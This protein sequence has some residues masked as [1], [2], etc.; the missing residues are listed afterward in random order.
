MEIHG[1][2][3]DMNPTTNSEWVEATVA[4]IITETPTVKRFVF[5][6]PRIVSHLAG[7][8][9]E[10]RLTGENGYQAARLYSAAS[11][12]QGNNSLELTI[13]YMQDGEV[14]PYMH[15]GVNIGD[16]LELRGPLGKFF[17]WN[18]TIQDP[19]LLIGAGSGV[20]PMKTILDAHEK[21]GVNTPINLLYSTRSF[22]DIIYKDT[23]LGN[24]HTTITLSRTS[25]EG[26]GGK[27]GRIDGELVRAS[28]R[29][30][31][32]PPLC[33]ICGVTSFVEAVAT[34]LQ[35]N[36]IPSQRIKAERYGA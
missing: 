21:A 6:F 30:Y 3:N 24:E 8:H 14:S 16:K 10:L 7:Q 15:E 17:V 13:A 2:N 35:D 9:Y 20:V 34:L 27:T 22:E 19:I 5:E 31:A 33:Y 18:E 25:P 23:L 26:W 1:A 11:I 32:V 12:S 28:L 4:D 29:L 36:G